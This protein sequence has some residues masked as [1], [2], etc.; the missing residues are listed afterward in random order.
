MFEGGWGG[1]GGGGRQKKKAKKTPA[2]KP[3]RLSPNAS[4]LVGLDRFYSEIKHN[5]VNVVSVSNKENHERI[6]L[7]CDGQISKFSK[8][9]FLHS[10]SEDLQ[11]SRCALQRSNK[12]RISST[13]QLKILFGAM[14]MQTFTRSN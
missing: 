7:L 5:K 9:D 4:Y 8:V 6:K 11:V 3:C 14:R 1:G 12:H 2:R 13:N 10:P